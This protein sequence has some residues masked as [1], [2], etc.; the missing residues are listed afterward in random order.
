MAAGFFATGFLATGVFLDFAAVFFL[1]MAGQ[2]STAARPS[3]LALRGPWIVRNVG[4]LRELSRILRQ[5][6]TPLLLG[7]IVLVHLVVTVFWLRRDWFEPLRTPDT[8]AHYVALTRLVADADVNGGWALLHALR[9]QSS[10]YSAF[11][12]LPLAVAGLLFQATPFVYRVA[13]VFYVVVLLVGVYLLGRRCHGRQAGLIAAAL[14]TLTPAVYG[15]WR[16]TGLDFP[17]LALTPLAILFLL[18]SEGLARKRDAALFGLF[19]GF[20]LLCKTQALLFLFWPGA[21]VLGRSVVEA[22]RERRSLRP[23]LLGAAVAVAVLAASTSLYWAGRLGFL[24]DALRIHATGEG[25][26]FYEGDTSLLGGVVH[27]ALCLPLLLSGVLTVALIALLPAFFRAS[28]DRWVILIWIFVPIALHILLKVRHHRYLFPLVPGVAVVLGVGL[29][30][31]R[32]RLRGVATA[33]V[34]TGAMV[35]WLACSFGSGNEAD[36]THSRLL[37]VVRRWNIVVPKDIPLP[38]LPTSLGGYVFTCGGCQYSGLPSERSDQYPAARS[39]AR[40]IG[41]RHPRGAGVLLFY[42][43]DLRIEPLMV[44]TQSL[45]PASRL[46]MAETIHEMDRFLGRPGWTVY[47]FAKGRLPF[48]IPGARPLVRVAGVDLWRVPEEAL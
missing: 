47:Y 15:G 25:M 39:F 41:Q 13:N 29:A 24:F 31:L 1:A 19:A 35:L 3:R 34:G 6:Q 36:A 28:R 48:E 33:V 10:H 23:V 14:V 27:Y 42:G 38:Q 8:F 40:W 22:R 21:Y 32:P 5:Y 4:P 16:T 37:S 7:W 11:A 18:R 2:Y 20:A 17:A 44:A 46:V 45:L 26:Y 43:G 9:D 12:H 30:S